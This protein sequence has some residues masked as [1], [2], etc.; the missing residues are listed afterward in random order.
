MP[1]QSQI[2]YAQQVI[3]YG[4][5]TATGVF[6]YNGTPALGNPPIFWITTASKDPYGNVIP[7]SVGIA[8]LPLFIYDGPPALGNLIY[9]NV[10]G[11]G[12]T[13]VYGNV[14][15]SGENSYAATGTGSFSEAVQNLGGVLKFYGNGPTGYTPGLVRSADPGIQQMQS[16]TTGT[17]DTQS[18]LD[19]Q[20]A[21][22]GG[23]LM[24]VS[25]NDANTYQTGVLITYLTA[26]QQITSESP[27][28][29]TFQNSFDLA[30]GL[31]YWFR[32][33][34]PVKG[35]SANDAYLNM[36]GSAGFSSFRAGITWI[37]SGQNFMVQQTTFNSNTGLNSNALVNGDFYS[38]IIEGF[39]TT[40]G[41]GSFGVDGAASANA[42]SYGVLAGAILMIAQISPNDG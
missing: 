4:T 7:P 22:N 5:G 38:C 23:L 31:E 10:P 3:V 8:D 35:L 34:L 26:E 41:S 1:W 18:V 12:G 37:G 2:V 25:G 15:L 29:I 9:S 20:S 11:A 28:G 16:G 32:A 24:F 33:Y 14:Y 36:A 40:N 27:T 39:G 21:N 17:G 42:T 6:V 30:S 13:D 19:L